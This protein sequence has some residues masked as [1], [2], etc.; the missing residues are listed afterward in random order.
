[1]S[2]CGVFTAVYCGQPSTYPNAYLNSSTGVQ[3]QDKAIFLCMEGYN[4]PDELFTLTCGDDG[5]WDDDGNPPSCT[6]ECGCQ[7]LYDESPEKK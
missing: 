4:P 6:G 7:M 2:Y 3:Y 5:L 1:M